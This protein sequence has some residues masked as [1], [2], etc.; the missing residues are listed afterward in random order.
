MTVMQQ[1]FHTKVSWLAIY[2]RFKIFEWLDSDGNNH[3]NKEPDIQS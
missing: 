1:C 2:S 3:M